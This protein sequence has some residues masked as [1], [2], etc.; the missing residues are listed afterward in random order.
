MSCR[1]SEHELLCNAGDIYYCA[2]KCISQ[3]RNSEFSAMKRK[4]SI[5]LRNELFGG[6]IIVLIF[7]LLVL[8]SCASN[9]DLTRAALLKYNSPAPPVSD[10]L[11][12]KIV[13]NSVEAGKSRSSADY[14]IGPEDLLEI[15]VFQVPD[16]K[17]VA[18]VSA[19]G[20]I[21]L[22]LVDELK[23][24]GETVSELE[25]L[26]AE[27]LQKYVKEP[28]VSVFVKEYRS[29]QISV[30]GAV[31]N[32][33]VYY[34]A[35]QKYLL[36]MLSLSGGLSPEAGSVC[37]VQTMQRGASGDGSREKIVID[38]DELLMNGQAELN[39]PVHSGDVIQVPKRGIFFVTGAVG[40]SGEFPLQGKPTITQALS[41]A[42]GLNYEAS[43]SDIKIYRVT[44]KPEREVVTV[45]YDEILA[46]KVLDPEI[47]D[48]DI[49]I[50]S[51]N[52]LKSFLRGIAGTLNFGAFS[53]G[54]AY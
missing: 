8:T 30:L 48:K 17:T 38:L 37:I 18:R 24:G 9:E 6:V 44:G 36:D 33:Q 43:H 16:L 7:F 12:G 11:N 3:G 49:I 35:G 21:K 19:R 39:I 53:L 41:M 22:P 40:Q 20:Y 42:K 5:L 34:V 27:K 25:S 10:T 54:R 1:I 51:N 28:V 15:D 14:Q 23:A 46:G 4:I 45:D 2:E 31:K 26:I 50:V 32:P 29:Q 52:K 47:K 13:R